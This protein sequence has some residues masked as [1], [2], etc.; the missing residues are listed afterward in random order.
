MSAGLLYA[1]NIGIYAVFPFL[2]AKSRAMQRAVS[3]Y[4][5]MG[6]VLTLGGFLGALYSFSFAGGSISIS[7]GSIA[8]GAFMMSSIMLFILEK[9]LSAL[10][11]TIRLVV[12]VDV[13]TFGLFKIIALALESPAMQNALGV[14]ASVFKLSLGIVVLGGVLIVLELFILVFMLEWLKTRIKKPVWFALTTVPLYLAVLI[15]DGVLFPMLVLGIGPKLGVILAGNLKSK[16]FLAMSYMLPLC[17]FLAVNKNSLKSF[18]QSPLNLKHLFLV[19]KSD[20]LA[21]I[22]RQRQTLESEEKNSATWRKA[23]TIFSFQ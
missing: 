12:I 8:Y 4:V 15:I 6:V 13:F 20:L 2:L 3:F 14:P 10:R 7:A 16:A 17:I 5:Y 19:P 22:E 23:S 18:I 1:I 11:D 21:E 9:D